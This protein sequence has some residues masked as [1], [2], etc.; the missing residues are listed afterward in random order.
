MNRDALRAA[1]NITTGRGPTTGSG[2]LARREGERAVARAL[3]GRRGRRGRAQG[4]NY[5]SR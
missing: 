3:S 5:E 1:R 4:F 2:V